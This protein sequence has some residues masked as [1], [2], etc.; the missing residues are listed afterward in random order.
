VNIALAFL[1]RLTDQFF[2]AQMQRAARKIAA[3]AQIFP[4]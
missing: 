4:R 3:R 2:E 1:S